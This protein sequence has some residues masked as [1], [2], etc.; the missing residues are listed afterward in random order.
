[1]YRFGVPT[2]CCGKSCRHRRPDGRESDFHLVWEDRRRRCEEG[3]RPARSAC[4]DAMIARRG[5]AALR[6]SPAGAR[7][8][9]YE[10]A[11]KK[12]SK[13][14]GLSCECDASP[15]FNSKTLSNELMLGTT[16]AFDARISSNFSRGPSRHPPTHPTTCPLALLW[17]NSSSSPNPSLK[18]SDEIWT[19]EVVYKPEHTLVPQRPPETRPPLC[20]RLRYYHA[21]RPTQ[22]RRG[23]VPRRDNSQI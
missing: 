11:E 3:L 5:R 7:L 9:G 15:E 17:A 18:I 16:S 22:K 13:P 2:L 1:M 23:R 12:Q 10:N 6:G 4:P 8:I 20:H 19:S 21:C 14:N